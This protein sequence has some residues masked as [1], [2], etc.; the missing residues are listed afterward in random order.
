MAATLRIRSFLRR[1]RAGFIALAAALTCGAAAHAAD[2]SVR[3]DGAPADLKPKLAIVSTLAQ[4]K[5]PLPTTAALRRVARND[6]VKI[7]NALKAAGYYDGATKF[8]IEDAD[9]DQRTVIFT[10][11][12]G[13]LFKIAAYQIV[14]DDAIAEDAPSRPKTLADLNIET[15]GSAAGARL[16]A[17]QQQA[18]TA[19]WGGGFPAARITGRR[20]QA[21]IAAGVADAIFTFESGPR[22]MFGAAQIEGDLRTEHQFL[23]DLRTW[24]E[25][26]VFDQSK[27]IA[28]RDRLAATGLFSNIDVAPGAV[29]DTGV[30]PVIVTLEER[31]RRTIGAGLSF[32]T[33]E[34]PGA[35]LFFEYRNL[36]RAGETA[37]V[38]L[39][40][41]AVEQSLRF[42]IDKPM[43]LFPGSIFANAGFTSETTEA[44]SAQSI[45]I[46]A[47]V[48]KRWLDDRLETRGGLAFETS[49]IVE[50]GVT[51]QTFFFSLPLIAI[52]NTED[53]PLTLARGSRLS[54][55]VTPFTGSQTFVRTEFAARSR[56]NFGPDD[57]FTLAGRARLGAIFANA[58]DDLPLNQRFFAGGGSSV[59]GFAFQEAGP[60]DTDGDPVGGTSLTE[61]AL[62]AR[63]MITDTIQIAAFVD[64]GNV[65]DTTLPDITGRYFVGAGAGARYFTPIGPL[66]VDFAF[67]INPRPSDANFQFFIS[68]GQSF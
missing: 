14:Y 17:L 64:A 16:Q 6:I 20:A 66:R 51:D 58:L 4:A 49:R 41:N 22:A 2:Y 25:G 40:G 29:S 11:R 24:E 26:A 9:A 68:L 30:A 18:L 35:R 33:A 23:K 27:L 60:L 57:R 62:E 21:N 43:P 5:R 37:R 8:D 38:D 3:I 48:T 42:N 55:T 65:S 31:K 44:F 13:P 32:S 54:L 50:D 10:V 34:G 59:R 15:D 67:P 28:Y 53:D 63:A 61:G 46:G 56:F 39:Q 7:N 19:L 1:R 52:W 36:F 45:D 47:G 12:A